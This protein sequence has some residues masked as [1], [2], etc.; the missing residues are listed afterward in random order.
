MILKDQFYF[1]VNVSLNLFFLETETLYESHK[2][3]NSKMNSKE[4]KGYIIIHIKQNMFTNQ[5]SYHTF[6]KTTA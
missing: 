6:V 4:A 3:G 5:Y 1:A 2:R